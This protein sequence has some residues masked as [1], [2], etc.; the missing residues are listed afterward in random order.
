MIGPSSCSER[1]RVL[2]SPRYQGAPCWSG[3]LR[4]VVEAR[5]YHPLLL[6]GAA[7]ASPRRGR[8]PAP[9]KAKEVCQEIKEEEP[10]FSI[11][12]VKDFD[13]SSFKDV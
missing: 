10:Y 12:E 1:T 3:H 4:V 8:G 11:V 5:V 13:R 6:P 9:S 2:G 7:T